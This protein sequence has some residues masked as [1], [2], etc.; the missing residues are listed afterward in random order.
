MEKVTG[1]P[2]EHM[3]REDTL[4]GVEEIIGKSDIT[5]EVKPAGETPGG[6]PAGSPVANDGAASDSDDTEDDKDTEAADTQNDPAKE[7]K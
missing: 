5:D 3:T 7:V 4:N 2:G 1:V 6:V